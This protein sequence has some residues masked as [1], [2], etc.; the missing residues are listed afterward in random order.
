MD[1]I[2][3]KISELE[4]Y[5]A[6][7]KKENSD[8]QAKVIALESKMFNLDRTRQ[9]N[10]AG[11]LLLITIV[12]LFILPQF[13]PSPFG[14]MVM[15]FGSAIVLTTYV[16]LQPDS[17]RSRSGSLTMAICLV[18]AMWLGAVVVTVISLIGRH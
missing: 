8:L 17:F 15:V 9:Q 18:T 5:H 6:S 16:Y 2:S 1:D 7:L 10:R 11:L 4:R 3:Y 13:I 12:V 14:E